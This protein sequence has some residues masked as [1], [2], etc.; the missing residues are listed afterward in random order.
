M[1]YSIMALGCISIQKHQAAVRFPS[2]QANA[3][4]VQKLSVGTSSPKLHV[5]QLHYTLLV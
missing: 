3:N 2:A 5:L 1:V 4:K